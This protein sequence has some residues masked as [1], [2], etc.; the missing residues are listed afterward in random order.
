MC[1]GTNKWIIAKAA[2]QALTRGFRSWHNIG[3][4]GIVKKSISYRLI[5]LVVG[6]L[7][8]MVVVLLLWISTP[9]EKVTDAGLVTELWADLLV[10]SVFKAAV[11]ILPL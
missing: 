4:S 6:I 1:S 11:T 8:A 5:T 3:K 7:V 9:G 10:K 2:K